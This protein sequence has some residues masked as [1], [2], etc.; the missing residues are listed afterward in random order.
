[1]QMMNADEIPRGRVSLERVEAVL[2]D[3]DGTLI[4][5]LDLILASMRFATETVLGASPPDEVLMHNVGVPL[6]VQMREF[7]EEKADELLRTYREHNARVHD[8]MV[9]EYPGV[10]PALES[11]LAGGRRLGIVT[12]KS[13]PVARRG[14]ERFSLERFFEVVVTC[15]DVPIHKPDPHPLCYAAELLGLPPGACAYVGDSPH[16]MTAALAAGCVAVAATWGVATR[17]RV[18]E[19]GPAYAVSSMAEVAALFSGEERRYS[20]EGAEAEKGSS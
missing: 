8:S 13:A 15:E 12:S 16:D 2:F 17:E 18:L 3:L 5:T 4:D 9:R 7:D 1:M 20:V 10:E 19:P 6:I 14:L 11:I